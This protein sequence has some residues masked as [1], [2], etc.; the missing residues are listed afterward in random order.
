MDEDGL[1]S[2]VDRRKEMIKYK[3]FPIAPA[4]VESVLLEHPA[5]RDAGVVGVADDDAGE[6]PCAFIVL[7]DGHP[8]SRKIEDELRGFVAERLT[9][10]KQPRRIQFVANVPRNPS[11]K[12]LR[13]DLRKLL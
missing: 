2:I 6:I 1:Y 9:P 3:G 11:G 13:R 4:E 5:V 10:Y 7:R 12:I 8:G